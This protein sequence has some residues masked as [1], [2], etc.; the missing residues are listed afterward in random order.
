[1]ESAVFIVNSEVR[2]QIINNSFKNIFKKDEK[3]VIDQLCG[4]AIGCVFP[5]TQDKDC[6]TTEEC[7]SC[8][9][10]EFLVKCLTE[11]GSESHS[12]ILEREFCINDV[13]KLKYF[14]V[15]VKYFTYD[16]LDLVMVMAQDLTEVEAQKKELEKLNEEKNRFIGIASHD[17]KNS[18]TAIQ[19][20]SSVLVDLPD[21]IGKED[22]MKLTNAI[23]RSSKFMG[24][25]VNDLL[26]ISV[27][28]AGK[29]ELKKTSTDY[30]SFINKNLELK[31][32]L[33]KEKNITIEV[34]IDE[35]IP[36]I[37]LDQTKI[38]QVLNNFID[39]A[40][41]FSI[42]NSTVTIEVS[43][44]EDSILTKI[45]DKGPGIPEEEQH[46]LFTEFHK[47]SVKPTGGEKSTGLG[48]AISKKIIETHGGKIGVESKVGEGS[49]FYFTIPI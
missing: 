47:T 44:E 39:N 28:E 8:I 19:G 34:K 33:A 41:K 15:T 31:Y 25:L 49:T 5:V 30:K 42:L 21:K 46:K 36:L 11:K 24:N 20:A 16:D 14:K 48:L 13:F 10:R 38:S 18:I 3:E 43:K 4:N 26:D 32:I 6:G 40:L 9:L 12:I 27:I 37:N 23:F 35:T 1:M 2:V 17:L 45:I 29:L 7:K 22:K